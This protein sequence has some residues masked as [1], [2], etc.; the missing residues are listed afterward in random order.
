MGALTFT[1]PEEL[2]Q[3][4]SSLSNISEISPKIIAAEQDVVLPEVKRRLQSSI[5]NKE[6]S[7]GDLLK[8]V[9]A[10]KPRMNSKGEWRGDIYF[11]GYDE[12]GVPNDRKAMSMEW[13]TSKQLA[14]PFL[15][16][17]KESKAS[18]AQEAAQNIFNEAV[19]K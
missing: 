11:E 7:K 9:K 13:G 1:V 14:A 15:R 3:K 16:P 19:S 2:M 12:K 8:S 17:A 18:E 10:S 6:D 4:I 5:K